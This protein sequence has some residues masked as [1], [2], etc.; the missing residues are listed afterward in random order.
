MSNGHNGGGGGHAMGTSSLTGLEDLANMACS[1][2][3]RVGEL[4]RDLGK[5]AAIIQELLIERDKRPLHLQAASS[6][7]ADGDSAATTSDAHSAFSLTRDAAVAASVSHSPLLSSYAIGGAHHSQVKHGASASPSSVANLSHLSAELFDESE[8]KRSHLGSEL[9]GN[10]G[11]GGGG[12][13][14]LTKSRSHSSALPHGLGAS[15]GCAGGSTSALRKQAARNSSNTTARRGAPAVVAGAGASRSW[16]TGSGSASASGTESLKGTGARLR[17]STDGL[18]N[19]TNASTDGVVTGEDKVGP[20]MPEP[21]ILKLAAAPPPAIIASVPMHP[22]GASTHAPTNARR[23][24]SMKVMSLVA[25]PRYDAHGSINLMEVGGKHLG[26]HGHPV[27]TAAAFVHS[28]LH[29]RSWVMVR[30]DVCVSMFFVALLWF[31]PFVVAFDVHG[32]RKPLAVSIS[33]L[34]LVDTVLN[35]LTPRFTDE[36]GGKSGGQAGEVDERGPLRRWASAY[37]RTHLPLDVITIVPWDLV[38]MACGM[39]G[40]RP[41]PFLLVR[42]LRLIRLR[43]IMARSPVFTRVR[44]WLEEKLHVGQ[45]F[46]GIF[47]LAAAM[48]GF[49]HV[50]ACIIYWLGRLNSF[51]NASIAHIQSSTSLLE[52]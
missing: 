25:T 37:T 14:G 50:Q 43:E 7:T 1:V 29:G 40:T 20:P 46:S 51:S 16:A 49:I 22:A 41:T 33:L 6:S 15:L 48:I 9:L 5:M 47:V 10:G 32:V 17:E 27:M 39:E 11:G 35:M 42:L 34:Y 24:L 36:D 52:Q 44:A 30:W 13:G 19:L 38:A 23:K 28:G 3:A 2:R 26:G 12:G 31:V 21:P 18:G 4:E 45:T 8:K